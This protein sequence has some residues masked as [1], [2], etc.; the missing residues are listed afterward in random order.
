MK[1]YLLFSLFL[2]AFNRLSAQK[3]VFVKCISGDCL[4]GTGVA[5]FTAPANDDF[6]GSVVYK[7][8]FK[9]GK[10]SGEGSV[11]NDHSYYIGTFE[12][13]YYRGYGTNFYSKKVG[14]ILVPDSAKSLDFCK[15][16]EDGCNVRMT[17]QT[18]NEKVAQHYGKNKRHEKFWG[19]SAFKDEHLMAQ[20][21]ALFASGVRGHVPQ[22]ELAIITQ[23]N[24]NASRGRAETLI[25]W[26]CLADR[27]YFVTA[28]ALV[29]GKL[30][31]LPFGGYVNCQVTAED[32][33]VVFEGPTDR[34]WKPAKDGKYTFSI[35]FDQG[36]I[37]G[38]DNL[39]VNSVNL[40]CSLRSRRQF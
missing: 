16:D 37:S 15:W 5:E 20:V 28:S 14:N 32:G 2:I 4:N 30:T 36:Q 31:I 26:D 25:T 27:Q 29:H 24:I 13:N 1:K 39:Y 40:G 9:E 11:M 23:K 34:Y 6:T 10:M 12:D 35:K 18:D 8:T 38:N 17:V 33:S 21:S 3:F 7:G 22:V 19:N